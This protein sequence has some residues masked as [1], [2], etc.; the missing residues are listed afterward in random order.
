MIKSLSTPKRE[1]YWTL[2][3]NISKTTV[4]NIFN[5]KRLDAFSL[6][7]KSVKMSLPFLSSTIL[8]ILANTIRQE[9]EI[10]VL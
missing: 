3:K 4:A 1:S 9:K 7:G 2:F 6:V 10:E 5:G 8:E